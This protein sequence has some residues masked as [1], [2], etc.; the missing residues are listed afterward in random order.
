[1]NRFGIY[2]ARYF[3]R[4]KGRWKKY[5]VNVV[6]YAHI[7]G[8]IR[9]LH[10]K[11]F[12][13]R[14]SFSNVLDAGCGNGPYS[15]YLAQK[16]PD[17]KIDSCDIEQNNIRLCHNILNTLTLINIRFF[18]KDIRKLN[19]HNKYDFILCVDV[20]EHIPTRDR[21]VVIKN[22]FESIKFGGYILL[23]VP[24]R[25]N[26]TIFNEK[27]FRKALKD[28]KETHKNDIFDIIDVIRLLTHEGFVV[29]KIKHTF[30]RLGQFLWE[31]DKILYEQS[32]LLYSIFLPFLKIFC[33]VEVRLFYHRGNGLL[34]LAMK[35]VR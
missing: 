22:L 24:I 4:N 13:K 23:H 15:F 29:N 21:R 27:F 30:G 7:G 32:K 19:T 6:G 16:Y 25:G 14:V 2:E 12:L 31:I 28:L 1:M 20:L 35:D 8:L 11:N 9:F 3:F 26:K 18:R 17:I 34:I 33:F 5:Y 10:I